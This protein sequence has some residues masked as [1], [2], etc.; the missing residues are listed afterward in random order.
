[1]DYR[2]HLW[3]HGYAV[4]RGVYS[5]DDVNAIAEEMDRLKTESLRYMASYRDRNV[6]FVI[7]PH[8]R[9]DRHLRFVHW[10]SYI[11]P[12]LAKY[13]VDLR[14]LKIL[15]PLIGN[16]LKQIGNQV[17]WKT[18]Q[19]TDTT[20]GFH[21]DARFR[22]PASA[23]RELATSYVQVFMAI[24][25]HR[26]E[27]GCLK[28]YPGSHKLGMVNLPMDR[29]VLEM[30]S[31]NSALVSVGLDPKRVV[32]IILDPGDIALWLPH[33]I[34]ASGPNLSTMDRRAYVNGYVVADNCDRGEWAFQHGEPCQLGE[35][36]L[37]QYDEL[38]TRP[39][40]HYIEGPIYPV[41]EESVLDHPE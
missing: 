21:Q 28:I 41:K 2:A 13:R 10:A 17:T 14:Q 37:V 36:S 5:M 24:D 3:D 20:F 27:N 7:R 15:E 9:L 16:H 26:V 1:M 38:F 4:I 34:H 8:P 12:V 31:E 29:S 40:P 11:S 32:N 33:T 18:P 39:E 35:P 30:E 23:F 22:R 25:P 6:V 19:S